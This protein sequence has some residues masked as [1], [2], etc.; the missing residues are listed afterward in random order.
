MKICKKCGT[1]REDDRKRCKVCYHLYQKEY[2]SDWG[3]KNKAKLAEASRRYRN[4]HKIPKKEGIIK[5]I[6]IVEYRRL[7]YLEHKKN[8]QDKIDNSDFAFMSNF[9]P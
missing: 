9:Q 5:T 4:K 8:T 2:K 6:G 7:Y 1:E 3:K